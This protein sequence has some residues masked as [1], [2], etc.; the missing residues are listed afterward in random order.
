MLT[1]LSATLPDAPISTR[2]HPYGLSVTPRAG[3]EHIPDMRTSVLAFMAT[4]IRFYGHSD[5]PAYPDVV[6]T[7]FSAAHELL[8][9]ADSHITVYANKQ[10]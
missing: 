8:R 10:F 9:P 1:R 7:P 5:Q 6:V 3:A 2:S 4:L